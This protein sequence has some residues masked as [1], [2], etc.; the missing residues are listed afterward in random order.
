MQQTLPTRRRSAKGFWQLTALAVAAGAFCVAQAQN[1]AMLSDPEESMEPAEVI[2]EQ[3]PTT[4]AATEAQQSGQEATTP[5]TSTSESATSTEPVQE[6]SSPA[7]ATPGISPR[8]TAPAQGGA[9]NG[10]TVV[11]T[12]QA[13]NLPAMPAEDR[14]PTREE[15]VADAIYANTHGL[16]PRG[17]VAVLHEDK[18]MLWAEQMAQSMNN[19]QMAKADVGSPQRLAMR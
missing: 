12:P 2:I 17:E 6:S 5:T 19:P 8:A 15:V 18:G 3:T 7:A 10:Q 16:I 9:A 1:P 14:P 4:P 11:V 13:T